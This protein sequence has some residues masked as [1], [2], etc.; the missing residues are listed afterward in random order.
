MLKSFVKTTLTRLL[1]PRAGDADASVTFPLEEQA[2]QIELHGNAPT[3]LHLNIL[4][5]DAKIAG[6]DLIPLFTQCAAETRTGVPPWRAFARMQSAAHLARYFLYS[7]SLPGARAECGVF[8]G[9]SA[10]F[11]C[12]TVASHLGAY[13]GSD[14][15]LID[16]FAGFP[17]SQSEDFFPLGLERSTVVKGPAFGE[18]DGAAPLDQVRPR[19]RDYPDITFHRGFIPEVF[20]ELPDTQW[21]FVHVDVD[22]YDPTLACL[23]YFYPR[24]VKGGVIICDDFGYKIF[25]G[26]RKAWEKYC[27]ENSISSVALETGQAAIIK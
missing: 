27:R 20:S 3:D 26:A 6:L 21:A 25:P 7:L 19:F 5:G 13:T 16:S 1:K 12:R 22:L 18:G 11:V 2:D 15:H 23:E 24:L 8:L 10:L 9:L 14:F 4:Y 17:K